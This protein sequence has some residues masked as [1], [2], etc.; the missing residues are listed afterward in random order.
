MQIANSQRT[1]K[2]SLSKNSEQTLSLLT[3]LFAVYQTVVYSQCSDDSPNWST[4]NPNCPSI[5]PFTSTFSIQTINHLH[6]ISSSAEYS[7]SYISIPIKY[8]TTTFN[9]YSITTHCIATTN[10]D[11]IHEYLSN[12]KPWPK[13]H[14]TGHLININNDTN[15][16][17]IKFNEPCQ[18]TSNTSFTN[19]IILI[20]DN[21]PF[22]YQIGTKCVKETSSITI[23]DTVRTD[24][25]SNCSSLPIIQQSNAWN[26][27]FYSSNPFIIGKLNMNLT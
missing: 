1:L 14:Q 21:N 25:S 7:Y 22:Q 5:K 4:I 24:I 11:S 8:N 3:V 15:N 18:F 13:Y 9:P 27:T 6:Q 23:Y 16:V 20:F 10:T 12:H 19:A 2:S 26:I 17:F